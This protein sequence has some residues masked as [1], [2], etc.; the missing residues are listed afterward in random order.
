MRRLSQY[1][2]NLV[3]LSVLLLGFSGMLSPVTAGIDPE[4]EI[5]VNRPGGDFQSF[6]VP[7]SDP[8]VCQAACQADGNCTAWTFVKPGVQG[9]Q[10]QCW[11]K[12]QTS[13]A[14]AAD[15]C[16]SGVVRQA[17]GT[18][19]GTNEQAF[20]VPQA[21][22]A[23]VDW[24]ETFG[25]NC[26]QAGADQFCRTQGYSGATQWQWFYA[27][28]TFVIGS[29]MFCEV[30][31]SCGALRDVS[32]TSASTTGGGTGT[33][34]VRQATY[35][36]NCGAAPGNVTG[37]LQNA[38][39]GLASCD[40]V[41]D[42]TVLGDPVAGCAKDFSVDWVCGNGAPGRATAAPEAGFGA[43]VR[44]LCPPQ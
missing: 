6:A 42:Y 34:A 43:R 16:I 41:V 21:N 35:G 20:A 12:N 11:L 4:M 2:L 36:A 13:Q 15:C 10:A 37:P 1:F 39:N 17:G 31:G 14:A 29:N 9:D 19:G 8:A 25:A 27:D 23:Y 5:G 18:Q 33:I 30:T 32:C 7:D 40:Y 38:C 28:R 3:F 26:G 44:L 22:G 24:C